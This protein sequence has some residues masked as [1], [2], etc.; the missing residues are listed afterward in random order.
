MM[1]VPTIGQDFI[2]AVVF[3]PS[4]DDGKAAQLT[5]PP[6]KDKNK[7]CPSMQQASTASSTTASVW[8][9]RHVQ[10][11]IAVEEPKIPPQLVS[12]SKKH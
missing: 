5:R 12:K 11:S 6:S 3:S 10:V 8:M 4:N 1:P 7:P 9:E 2:A